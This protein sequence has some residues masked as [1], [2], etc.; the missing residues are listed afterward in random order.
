MCMYFSM[1][2]NLVKATTIAVI[3]INVSTPIVV[4]I[5]SACINNYTMTPRDDY[6]SRMDAFLGNLL[7]VC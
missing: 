4:N 7:F 2:C 5:L 6:S 1:L 3:H